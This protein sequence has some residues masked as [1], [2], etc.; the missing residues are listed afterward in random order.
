MVERHMRNL[1]QVELTNNRVVVDGQDIS[2]MVTAASIELRVGHHPIL[3]LETLPDEILFVGEAETDG[4]PPD[5]IARL[6]ERI[7]RIGPS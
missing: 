2:H 7:S 5:G 1:R 6:R 3:T 4:V